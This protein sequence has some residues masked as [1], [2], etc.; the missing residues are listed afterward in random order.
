MKNKLT[1]F[2]SGMVA[3]IGINIMT[4]FFILPKQI[5]LE[6]ES[7]MNFDD[8]VEAITVSVKKNNWSLPHL[9]DL[10]TT[11]KKNNFE[12]IL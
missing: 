9:Y 5:F 1:M 4:V 2:I 3:G 7:K 8:T 11:M 10:Q 6:Y 12:V